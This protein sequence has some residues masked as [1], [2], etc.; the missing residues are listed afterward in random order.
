MTDPVFDRAW[1]HLIVERQGPVATVTLNRPDA[2]NALS[3][4]LMQELTEVA[5]AL[6]LLRM[7]WP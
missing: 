1:A 5:R 4:A 2:R 7:C 6:R 3:T